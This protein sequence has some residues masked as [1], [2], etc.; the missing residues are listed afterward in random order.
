MTEMFLNC[1]SLSRGRTNGVQVAVSY[2]GCK[3]SR[4]AL[5]DIFDGLGTASG[6]QTIDVRG[7]FGTA[8]LTAPD[9]EIAENKGWTV[10]H[11]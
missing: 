5:I 6:A 11:T 3:L 8:S 1:R 9:R 10:Q 7:N 2:N 4:A